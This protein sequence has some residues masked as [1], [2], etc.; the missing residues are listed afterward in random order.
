MS[1]LSVNSAL[2]NVYPANFAPLLPSTSS[3]GHLPFSGATKFQQEYKRLR[4]DTGQER[5]TM[6][7]R[8]RRYLHQ[9][10]VPKELTLGMVSEL[11]GGGSGDG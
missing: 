7:N 9:Y 5:A 6:Y 10:N 11:L 2:A 8:L 1:E 3:H 4:G